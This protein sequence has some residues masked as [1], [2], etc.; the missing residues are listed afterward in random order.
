MCVLVVGLRLP[1][2]Q[3]EA[4]SKC[5]YFK[6]SGK[7]S[8][9]AVGGAWFKD[10]GDANNPNVNHTWVEGVEACSD[11]AG[12]SSGEAAMQGMLRHETTMGGMLRAAGQ[13]NVS[14]Q[15]AIIDDVHLNP[16]RNLSSEVSQQHRTTLRDNV[17]AGIA[18]GHTYQAAFGRQRD[19]KT[20]G[21]LNVGIKQQNKSQATVQH[22]TAHINIG[23]DSN[24]ETSQQTLS[25][26]GAQKRGTG[27]TTD[28][29][30]LHAGVTPRNFSSTAPQPH[31]I[32][33]TSARY[34]IASVLRGEK[35]ATF[36]QRNTATGTS[37]DGSLNRT[38]QGNISPTV[39]ERR[40]TTRTTGGYDFNAGVR[41]STASAELENFAA[42]S[43]F[44]L[45]LFH[46]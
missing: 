24:E 35:S 26:T 8:C 4:C 30:A 41:D 23:H 45:A 22:Q 7:R 37:G 11:F 15:Q 44:L 28:A 5:G 27:S 10:C 9:C 39:A 19:T 38:T 33:H 36:S 43:V 16:E 20:D 25:S 6:K 12:E 46:F 40:T 34:S 2:V 3:S 32:T 21:D 42:Y 18:Q 14:R 29:G 13:W 31:G 17:N 1:V